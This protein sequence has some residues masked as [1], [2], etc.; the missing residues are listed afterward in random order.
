MSPENFGVR[1]AA[2][3]SITI[4]LIGAAGAAITGLTD[5]QD[6]DPPAR[7]VGLVHGLL[8]LVGTSLFLASGVMR[9]RR[10]RSSGRR[11]AILG[12]TVAMAADGREALDRLRRQW[13]PS[14]I[15]LDLTMPVMNGWQFRAEQ[16]LD[17]ALSGIPVVVLSA[18]RPAGEHAGSAAIARDG[19]EQLELGMTL[20]AGTFALALDL[21]EL[22]A[23]VIR[24]FF[25]P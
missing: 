24:A 3:A 12:Y 21:L 1:T 8:N 17:P 25:V 16:R 6:V 23:C 22:P 4:G 10:S 5:W 14:L 20:G 9:K 19:V 18:V 7:R 2:D 15:L 13:R 11:L